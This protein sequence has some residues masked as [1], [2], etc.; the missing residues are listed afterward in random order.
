MFIKNKFHYLLSTDKKALKNYTVIS[1]Q[2]IERV[3]SMEERTIFRV[4]VYLLEIKELLLYLLVFCLFSSVSF[5]LTH[6]IQ[7]IRG[8]NYQV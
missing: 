6:Y 4:I 3:S 2:P 8:K 5:K 1:W 7:M